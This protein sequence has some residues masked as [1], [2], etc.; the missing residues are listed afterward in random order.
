MN[1]NLI[2]T[3]LLTFCTASVNA[4][5]N[6]KIEHTA[7]KDCMFA[8]RPSSWRVLDTRHMVLW[9][10]SQQDTY[11]VTLFSPLIDLRSSDVIAFI[12]AD[13]NNKL[14]GNRA[15]KIATPN[16]RID[17]SPTLIS[18]MVKLDEQDLI[19]LGK[20]YNLQLLSPARIK[21]LSE[22]GH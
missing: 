18:S 3:L 9:G 19:T 16:S 7:G 15:D 2:Y 5:P 13:R 17:S 11:L 20:Q 22:K 14:C 1:K 6:S 21:A 4:Q 10:P 12:D 8:T